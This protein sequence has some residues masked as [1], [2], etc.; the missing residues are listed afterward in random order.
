ML[1]WCALS[2]GLC[3]GRAWILSILC[4]LLMYPEFLAYLRCPACFGSLVVLAAAFECGEIVQGDLCCG[5]CRVQ[6]PI[7]SGIPDLRGSV[8]SRAFAQ[9]VNNWR[10]TAWGYERFWR[11]YALTLLSRRFLSY[12]YELRLVAGLMEPQRGGLYVDVACANGLYARALTRARHD[13]PGHVVGVDHALPMLIEARSRARAA[14]LRISYVCAQAQRLPFERGAVSGV[15][16]GG[17][18]NEIGD[19][20]GCLAEVARVLRPSGRFVAMTLTRSRRAIGWAVQCSM[21]SGGIQFWTADDLVRRFGDYHLRTVGCWWYGIVL[22]TFAV[23]GE[24]L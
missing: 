5:V 15:V 12:R 19:L 7:R 11:P 13:A 20:D 4:G 23:R 3:V 10:A 24:V 17:S 2:H 9:V 6:Y 8:R 14:G 18:L 21:R 1:R 16:I 22:F